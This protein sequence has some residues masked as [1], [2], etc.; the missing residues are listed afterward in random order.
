MVITGY[1]IAKGNSGGV[2]IVLSQMNRATSQEEDDKY[3]RENYLKD[4]ERYI[5]N[6]RRDGN[7]ILLC[8]D[9]NE[10]ITHKRMQDFYENTGLI[11]IY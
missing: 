9:A 1:N 10:H 11:N 4:L 6:L 3:Y 8:H 5:K 7:E 2:D